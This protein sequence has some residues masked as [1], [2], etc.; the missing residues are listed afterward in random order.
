MK[1]IFLTIAIIT[2]FSSVVFAAPVNNMVSGDREE[3]GLKITVEGDFISER[4]LD[5]PNE[6]VDLEANFYEAKIACSITDRIDIY[7]LLGSIKDTQVTEKEI[8]NTYKYFFDDDFAWGFGA[9]VLVHEFENGL[10][11]DADGKYRAAAVDLIEIDLNGTKYSITDISEIAGNYK[12]WQLSLG[13]AKE[14]GEIVK[15]I[16]YAGIKYS[17]VEVQAKGTVGGTT[18]QTNNVNSKDTV[19]CY[20]GA[21]IA[22]NDNLSLYAEGRFIDETA[23]STGFTW[24]F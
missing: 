4:E 24:K 12:E 5:M 3:Y 7:A 22:F 13:M 9:S 18:Y 11:I 21:E 20:A 14:F 16:P 17:D 8:S 6:S 15:F 2:V 10:R 23:V 19:G 1:K